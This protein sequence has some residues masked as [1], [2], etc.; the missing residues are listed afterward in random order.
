MLGIS[1]YILADTFFIANGI[2]AEG[3]AALNLAI[4]IYSF[5]HGCALMLGTGGATK[6]VIAQCQGEHRR[7]NI[8]FTNSIKIGMIFA[9]IFICSGLFLSEALT[10]FLKADAALWDMTNTYLKIILLFSQ[11]IGKPLFP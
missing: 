1:C 9:L 2:G 6:F 5:I 8:I 3:L 11:L 7:A 10:T 4:P